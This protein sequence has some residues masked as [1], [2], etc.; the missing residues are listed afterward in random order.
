M[1]RSRFNYNKHHYNNPVNFS[2][3]QLG[4]NNYILNPLYFYFYVIEAAMLMTRTKRDVITAALAQDPS[5]LS[6]LISE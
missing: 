6:N 3:F 5:T 2:L 4:F 1:I